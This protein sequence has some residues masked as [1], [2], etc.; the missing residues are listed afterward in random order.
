LPAETALR[1]PPEEAERGCLRVKTLETQESASPSYVFSAFGVFS[2]VTNAFPWLSAA[3]LLTVPVLVRAQNPNP[4]AGIENFHQ[5]NDH[6]YRGAQPGPEGWN[7]LA[8]M[9]ITTIIDLRR[10]DE[11]DIQ[12]ERRVVE[13]AGMH[14]V[15]VPMNGVVAPSP[16]KVTMILEMLEDGSAGKVFVHCKRGADRTGAV[17]ACYRISHDH[18]A[19]K[20]ALHEA[21]SYGMS[22]LQFG[23]KHYV[24]TYVPEQVA[25]QAASSSTSKSADV[26]P[27]VIAPSASLAQ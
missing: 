22:R 20:R 4:P 11:H 24:K 18:W 10:E 27:G 9:G 19:N 23:I 16:E 25:T 21:E 2:T 13:A 8:K 12:E 15:S 3:L 6:V 5:V 1:E 14:Y 26:K 7:G 17:I